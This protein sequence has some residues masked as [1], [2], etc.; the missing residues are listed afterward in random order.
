MSTDHVQAGPG[1]KGVRSMGGGGRT[2]YW[3]WWPV[4][5]EKDPVPEDHARVAP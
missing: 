3:R 1:K 5:A 4:A 2:G